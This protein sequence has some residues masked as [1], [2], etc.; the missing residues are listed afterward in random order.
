MFRNRE[1]AWGKAMLVFWVSLSLFAMAGDNVKMLLAPIVVISFIVTI[2]I[3]LDWF[4]DW[5]QK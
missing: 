2:I 3:G 4:T 5:L 1:S